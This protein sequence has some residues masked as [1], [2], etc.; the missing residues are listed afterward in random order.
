MLSYQKNIIFRVVLFIW[1]HTKHK[2]Q[3]K[4]N[5]EQ[6]DMYSIANGKFFLEYTELYF[7]TV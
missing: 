2:N 4:T 1:P 3:E 7:F 5:Y 6:V